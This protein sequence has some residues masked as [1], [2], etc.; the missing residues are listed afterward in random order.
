MKLPYLVV[1]DG[2]GNVFEI[3]DYLMAGMSLNRAILPE[4]EDLIPLPDGSDLLELPG[5]GAVGYDPKRGEFV[6]V[7]TY[8]DNPV[9]AAAAFM[10]PAYLQ[11]YRCAFGRS[12]LPSAGHSRP[13]LPTAGHSRP[14]ES[15]PPDGNLLSLYAYTAVG[16]RDGVFS[17]TGTR[18]DAD[19]RQDLRHMD[20]R[21]IERNARK[22]AKR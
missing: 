21:T 15:R 20:R 13:L 7:W 10:A 18:I 5:R 16:W 9:Y 3:P 12:R 17:V 8:R 2:C 6:E 14:P 19:E 1:S 22:M 4:P 11:Y